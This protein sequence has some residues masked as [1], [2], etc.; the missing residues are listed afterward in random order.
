MLGTVVPDPRAPP[1]VLVQDDTEIAAACR[2]CDRARYP[3]PELNA[4]LAVL[5]HELIQQNH[6]RNRIHTIFRSFP[7]HQR[8][9]G[10]AGLRCHPVRLCGQPFP[11]PCARQHLGRCHGDRGLLP[12]AV[13]AVPAGC[14][15]VLHGGAHAY[16]AR[17]LRVVS[18]PAVPLADGR[19]AAARAGLEHP[20]AGHGACD[21]G[22]ARSDALRTPKTL[23]AGTLSVLRRVEPYLDHD[24]PASHRLGARLH[25]HLFLASPQTVLHA[26]GALSARGCRA[27]PDAV[28]AGCLPGWPQRRGRGRRRGMA[29]AQSHAPPAGHHGRGRDARPHH[30]RPHRRL[31][32]TARFG[33]AGAW[34]ARPVRAARRHDRAVLRQRQDGARPQ[35]PLRAGSEPA[36]QCA[37]CQR[38]RRPR[39]LL[40]LPHPH[41]R[42]SWRPARAVA[43]RGVRAHPCRHQ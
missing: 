32:R 38:L 17:H 16:G 3:P 35:G 37:A 14:D 24:D 15:R 40:D 9:P 6:G 4:T 26:R 36:P 19:A 42:R 25:R 18:A 11:Q 20:R 21:R 8:T 34:R 31:S 41:H 23:S 39:P 29:D 12:H 1:G 10:A 27:D 33:A 28:A 2:A 43:A 7:R 22:A 13:L 5:L 30:R